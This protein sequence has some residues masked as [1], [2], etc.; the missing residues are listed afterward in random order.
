MLLE[1]RASSKASAELPNK[2]RS[3]NDRDGRMRTVGAVPFVPALGLTIHSPSLTLSCP[4]PRYDE[5]MRNED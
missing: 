1:Q 3:G 5:E 4:S 2:E